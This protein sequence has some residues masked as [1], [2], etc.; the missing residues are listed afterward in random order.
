MTK[1]ELEKEIFLHLTKVNFSTFNEMKNMFKCTNEDLMYTIK[2]NIKT[3]SNPLG[4]ILINDETNVKEYSIEAAK[5][6][7]LFDKIFWML[8]FKVV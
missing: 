4:F 5:K 1:P 3:D 7:K 2:K 8:V 6:S